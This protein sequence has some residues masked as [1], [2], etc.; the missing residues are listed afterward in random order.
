[1]TEADPLVYVAAR[2]ILLDA[3]DALGE[4]RNA[5]VLVGAQ[6]IYLQ[7]GEADLEVSVAPFT[8]DADLS[9]DPTRLGSDPRIAEAMTEAGFTLKIKANDG[10]VEPGTWLAPAKINEETIQVPVDLLVP[11]TLAT[12]RGRRD[13]KLPDHGRNATRW[14]PGLEAT[15]VD[16]T[17]MTIGSLEP[18]VDSR[19]AEIRVAGP[20][21]LLVAKSHKIA[22]RLVDGDRGRQDRVKPK[23]CADVIRLMRAETP[24]DA[25]GA[26]LAELA[27]HP[28]CGASVTAGVERLAAQFGGPS[29]PG[30]ELA[31]TALAGALPE[32][33]L[34]GLAPTYIAIMLD[35]YHR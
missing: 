32:D 31:V 2:R 34:R 10:G 3:L 27:E 20:A 11:E 12:S 28:M 23:D 26:R 16:N 9:I 19:T 29:S 1:M 7:A 5:V 24:P 4:H 25:V 15:I 14:T 22:D 35:A 13:A 33:L 30:V 21:A 8:T 6:A 17:A 18:D